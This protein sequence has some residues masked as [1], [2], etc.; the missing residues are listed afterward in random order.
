MLYTWLVNEYLKLCTSTQQFQQMP[1]FIIT[2][3]IVN[4]WFVWSNLISKC[5]REYEENG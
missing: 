4:G 2:N 3:L 1:K 5:K